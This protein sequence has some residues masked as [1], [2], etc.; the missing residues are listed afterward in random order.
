[1]LWEKGT[2]HSDSEGISEI[3]GSKLDPHE[4]KW[5]SFLF[6]LPNVVKHL[7]PLNNI[8]WHFIKLF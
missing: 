1:M 5:I 7:L 6:L 2:D 3:L 4:K 8:K